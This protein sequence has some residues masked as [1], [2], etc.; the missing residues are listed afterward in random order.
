MCTVWTFP[1]LFIYLYMYNIYIYIFDSVPTFT[2]TSIWLLLEFFWISS[3]WIYVHSK[4]PKLCILAKVG[5]IDSMA[6][7]QQFLDSVGYS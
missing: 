6:S 3:S 5:Y 4:A 2:S 7:E 1:H